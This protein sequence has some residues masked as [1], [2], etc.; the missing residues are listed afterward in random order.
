MRTSLRASG[1]RPA[2]RRRRMA[3]LILPGR[4][5][6][7]IASMI[8]SLS[9]WFFAPD[10]INAGSRTIHPAT[11][12]GPNGR[13]IPVAI[14]AAA[15]APNPPPIRTPWKKLFGKTLPISVWSPVVLL[16]L[17][18]LRRLRPSDQTS[19]MALFEFSSL[20]VS[21]MESHTPGAFPQSPGAPGN[22][23]GKC[24]LPSDNL[25]S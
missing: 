7:L 12:P 3:F 5:A 21:P 23:S 18:F 10:I 19:G 2:A 1:V 15:P 13:I 24:R 16:L 22:K 9:I 14:T 4:S 6:S 20:R 17:E 11:A 8:L 25:F